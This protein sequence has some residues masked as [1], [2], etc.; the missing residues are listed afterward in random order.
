MRVKRYSR[1]SIASA[2]L[3][4]L[5]LCG[6]G[7]VDG[8]EKLVAQKAP[9]SVE[10]SKNA[11]KTTDIELWT[12]NTG[13]KPIE[14]DTPA[15]N[16]YKNKLGVGIIQPYVEW[17]GGDTYLQQL[18]LKIAAGEMPDIFTPWNGIEKDLAEN[19]AILDL[20]NLLPQK[21]P[22]FWKLIPKD[23]WAVMA[24]GD[25]KGKGRIFA[26]PTLTDY[27]MYSGLIRKDWLDKLGLAVPKT[28]AELE[29]VLI[30]FRDKDPNGNGLKDEIPTGGRQNLAWMD[31]LFAMYGIAIKEGQ[32]QWDLYDGKLTY[33]AVTKNMRDALEWISKL[34]A[35][36]LLDNETLLN[37]KTAW[38][39]KVNTNRV[40]VFYRIS[41]EMY[42]YP[43]NIYKNTGVKAEFTTLPA[44][45][46][47]GYKGFYT[48]M[49]VKGPQY[50][51]K[52]QKDQ[53]KVDA[54]FKYLNA[55]ANK[56]LW[57]DLYLGVK[58]MHHVEKDGKMIKLA[59]DKTT[60]VNLISPY[61]ETMSLDFYVTML[62]RIEKDAPDRKWA[63]DQALTVL[64]ESQKYARDI[65]GD[66]I[67][68]SVYSGYPD[69]MNRKL[70]IEYASKI[71]MGVYPI[72]KF[73]EFVD[74]WY[75]AGGNEVTKAARDWYAKVGK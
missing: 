40:G 66:G 20:T 48:M 15:Y 30:A 34:Y 71:M 38:D 8:V 72:S 51:I 39:G 54:C 49:K 53:A 36:G 3:Y 21:A 24:A 57:Y 42:M 73:D 16:F 23:S 50:V 55:I 64:K 7:P 13:F 58:D 27:C 46:A 45:S 70:Y 18:N 25:P 5:V 44:I 62:E 47:P 75:S 52:N 65:A 17:N 22:D 31:H 33:S 32:P 37:D 14:K 2:A 59:D 60:Q 41:Q 43:E 4:A 29:K 74:K 19:D 6:F 56:D 67:P 61:N 28:Q 69:I 68:N 1:F 10:A 35:Q 63:I 9:S 12:T 11:G 26:T